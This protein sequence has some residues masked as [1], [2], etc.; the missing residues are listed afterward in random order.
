MS[1][2]QATSGAPTSKRR[3]IRSG[4]GGAFPAGIGG[5][6]PGRLV[7]AHDPVDPHQSLDPLVVHPSTPAGQLGG[8]AG[9]AVG[10][11]ELVVD[12]ADLGH[13]GD[14][15]LLGVAG[16]AGPPGPPVVER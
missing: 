12:L 14:L 10:P 9:L 7:H 8:D 16:P 3:P 15:G 1:P 11:V 2:T 4:S 13:Q 5:P 6:Y